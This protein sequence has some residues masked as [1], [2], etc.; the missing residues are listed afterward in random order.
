M[1]N[2]SAKFKINAN[3]HGDNS[4]VADLGIAQASFVDAISRDLV[5]GS[6]SG[7]A[8][9]FFAD[10]ITRTGGTDEDIDLQSDLDAVGVALGLDKLKILLIHNLSDAVLTV[11][12]DSGGTVGNAVSLFTDPDTDT[13]LIPALGSFLWLGGLDGIVVDA[14]HKVLRIS[15]GGAGNKVFEVVIVGVKT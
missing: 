4:D 10:S 15:P 7:Q 5:D 12:W 6:G 11:G 3:V 14:T 9:K 13:L 2:V 8:N 1:N